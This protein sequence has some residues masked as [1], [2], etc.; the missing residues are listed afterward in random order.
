MLTLAVVNLKGG[1][2]KTTSAAFLAHALHEAGLRTAGVDADG[3]NESFVGWSRDAGFP[4]PVFELV[5]PH[6]DEKLPGVLGEGRFDACVID[7]PPMKERFGIVRGAV[8]WASHIVVPMAPTPMEYKRLPAVRELIDEALT[9]RPGPR[10]VLVVLLTRTVSGAA[11]TEVWRRQ[12]REDGWV[13]LNPTV[14]R[15]ERFSQAY[16][17]P[18]NNAANT[19]YGFAVTELL[20]LEVTA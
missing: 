8:R 15:L 17:D 20:D 13:V 12:V 16:G 4:F 18:I 11:S 5:G 2:G 9:D 7:T 19:A 6:L 3:E 10:P 14:G 1:T